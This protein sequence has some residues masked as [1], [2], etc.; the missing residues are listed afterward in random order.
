P[1]ADRADAWALYSADGQRVREG[2]DVP[3]A[4]PAAQRREAV[5]AASR[6]RL[7]TLDLPPLP[8]ERV[9]D[10]VAYAIEDQLAATDDRP[11]IAAS[12]QGP[13]GRVH[14]SVSSRS[15]VDALA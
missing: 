9:P 6:A 2:R 10:A 1:A 3:A 4:W 15:L 5:I 14:A 12:T 11:R 7:I 13:D 8:A